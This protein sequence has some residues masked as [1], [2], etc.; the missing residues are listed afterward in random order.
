MPV[1]SS[2]HALG[3]I[4]PML[5]VEGSIARVDAMM[6]MEDAKNPE[7]LG[8]LEDFIVKGLGPVNTADL[9]QMQKGE[10]RVPDLRGWSVEL[11]V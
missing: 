6:D 2:G 10:M 9:S 3:L 8:R 1:I 11:R 5:T 4:A 7:F